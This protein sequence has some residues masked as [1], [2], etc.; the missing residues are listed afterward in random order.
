[1]RISGN[2]LCCVPSYVRL[3]QFNKL[4]N[5]TQMCSI[6]AECIKTHSQFKFEICY[7][8][9]ELET[10]TNRAALWP[11]PGDFIFSKKS[12]TLTFQTIVIFVIKLVRGF[13]SNRSA[14][15]E[16]QL[17]SESPETDREALISSNSAAS[18]RVIYIPTSP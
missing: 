3:R 11:L 16:H 14:R 4:I 13:L 18:R 12:Q 9:S 2:H 5:F 1:M 17:S 15:Y 6:R 8:S 7:Y 10:K